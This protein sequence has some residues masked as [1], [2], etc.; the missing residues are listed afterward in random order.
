MYV[1]VCAR[2]RVSAFSVCVR[3]VDV[4]VRRPKY[5]LWFVCVRAQRIF[6]Q[7]QQQQQ[8][9]QQLAG[10]KPILKPNQPG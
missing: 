1:R 2:A 5:D 10:S 6:V 7:Q 3:V 8:Q 4:F 9:Q